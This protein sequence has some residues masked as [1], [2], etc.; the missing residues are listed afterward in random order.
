MSKDESSE[1]LPAPLEC[2][3]RAVMLGQGAAIPLTP[4]EV[5]AHDARGIKLTDLQPSPD[6]IPVLSWERKHPAA[7]VVPFSPPGSLDTL[8]YAARTR[9]GI[10]AETRARLSQ[11]LRDLPKSPPPD[12]R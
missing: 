9:N 6:A 10:S 11:L 8:A 5:A 4:R 1:R 2:V 7:D 3:L 12:G